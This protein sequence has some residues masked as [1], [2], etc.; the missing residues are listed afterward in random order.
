[1]PDVELVGGSAVVLSQTGDHPR[2]FKEV[3]EPPCREVDIELDDLVQLDVVV[4]V[5]TSCYEDGS[6]AVTMGD[7]GS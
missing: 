3:Q 1:M 2:C 6:T 7:D 4:E 5:A